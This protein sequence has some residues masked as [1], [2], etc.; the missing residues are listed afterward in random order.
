ML[1][2][3]GW[4]PCSSNISGSN[5]YAALW[6]RGA[7]LLPSV[8]ER[9]RGDAG[10]VQGCVRRRAALLLLRLG[11]H[12][13]ARPL[14][15][16]RGRQGAGVR[17]RRHARDQR[18]PAVLACRVPEAPQPALPAPERRAPAGDPGLRGLG[19]RAQRRVPLELRHRPRG[20]A[21]VVPGRRPADGAEY[22]GDPARPRRDPQASFRGISGARP[23][24]PPPPPPRGGG[25]PP[26][27][28]ATPGPPRARAA[29]TPPR[30]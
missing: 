11:R 6:L 18:R 26:P 20:P 14:R 13:N 28:A 2:T 24:P 7:R 9:P 17:G 4:W 27:S 3:T 19:R 12:L 23:P 10:G 1:P 30:V 25:K 8:H 15:P 29:R 21:A 16:R 5:D 22:R